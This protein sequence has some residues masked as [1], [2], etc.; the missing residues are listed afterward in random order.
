MDLALWTSVRKVLA[1]QGCSGVPECVEAM[2]ATAPATAI[3]YG[4]YADLALPLPKGRQL[5]DELRSQATT[6][7]LDR[8]SASTVPASEA[9]AGPPPVTT[10]ERAHY[11][12]A[13]KERLIR[14]WDIEPKNPMGLEGG[15]NRELDEA[16]AQFSRMFEILEQSAPELFE[17]TIV[18][19]DEIVSVK[20]DGSQ[21]FDYDGGSSFALWGAVVIN[22]D[23]HPGWP[24]YCKTLVHEAAHNVLFAIARTEPLLLNDPDAS[25]GS[26]LRDDPRPM[27]G[28]FHA[29]FVAAR[30]SLAFDGILAWHEKTGGL[31]SQEVEDVVEL[32]ETSVITFW[33]CLE[34]MENDGLPS[35]LGKAILKDCKDYMSENFALVTE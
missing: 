4:A 33:Q 12:A 13:D 32:F 11:S 34:A 1:E 8:L 10:L 15:A 29:A 6:H 16:R 24:R 14:W 5:T 25:Y 27:D 31:S 20:P 23:T 19:V 30:E 21:R 28:I 2:S 35:D 9:T 17:E 22:A 3:D 18:I 7:L 26:P